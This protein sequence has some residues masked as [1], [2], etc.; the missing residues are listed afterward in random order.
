MA[1]VNF[2]FN[3]Q[4]IEKRISTE[5]LRLHRALQNSKVTILINQAQTS[6]SFWNYY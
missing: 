4:R 2:L 3:D 6:V 5:A 1:A